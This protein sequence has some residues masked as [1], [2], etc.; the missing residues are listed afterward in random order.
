[1]RY[2]PSDMNINIKTQENTCI[3]VGSEVLSLFGRIRSKDR[4]IGMYNYHGGNACKSGAIGE[5]TCN[6]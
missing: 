6:L 5:R 1:M 4:V 3:H 2:R